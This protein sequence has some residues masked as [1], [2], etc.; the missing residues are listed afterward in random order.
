MG[1]TN[2]EFFAIVVFVVAVLGL[3]AWREIKAK[4]D[5]AEARME[6]YEE[7]ARR[8]AEKLKEQED[9]NLYAVDAYNEACNMEPFCGEGKKP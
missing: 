5:E 8:Y 2:I 3:A 6:R 7:A 1:M 9:E 4:R